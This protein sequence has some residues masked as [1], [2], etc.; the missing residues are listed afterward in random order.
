VPTRPSLTPE[1]LLA[2]FPQPVVELAN[3]LRPFVRTQ[4]PEVHEVAYAGWKAIG[5]RHPEAGYLGAIFL[6]EDCV[7]FI[8]EHG[9]LLPDAGGILEG[10][11]KQTRHVTMPPG[12]TIPC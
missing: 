6:F 4:V 8:F 10:D 9:H 7:R 12:T 3:A 11:T 1:S 2:Q 5:Y